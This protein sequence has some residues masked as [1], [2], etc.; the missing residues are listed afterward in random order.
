MADVAHATLSGASLHENKGV[1]SAS[2]NTVATA[3]NGVTVWQKLTKDNLTGTA[4]A[5]A[6]QYMKVQDVKNNNTAGGSS[7]ASTW[8]RRD[9]NTVVTNQID[10]AS[11]N[12]NQIT[13]P[14]GT[15]YIEG[16]APAFR[17]RGHIARLQNITDN[18][19]AILGMSQ[20]ASGDNGGGT[21]YFMGH[22]T[23]AAQKTF[24]VQHYA[25]LSQST[26]GFGFPIGSGQSE[27]YTQVNIW[28]IA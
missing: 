27:V 11:L 24:E 20:Y 16:A 19:T 14:A 4:N 2:D 17:T 21:S 25:Q 1:S 3:V 6:S 8:T 13:L 5:F 9:L 12:S 15:Y 22:V 18:S 10:G 26:N 28:K 23:I 7:V